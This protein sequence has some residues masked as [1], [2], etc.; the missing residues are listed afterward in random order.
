MIKPNLQEIWNGIKR[1]AKLFYYSPAFIVIILLGLIGFTI[2]TLNPTPI[3]SLYP[4]PAPYP[5]GPFGQLATSSPYPTYTP[6]PTPKP[7]KLIKV[8]GNNKSEIIHYPQG[9][10]QYIERW[11]NFL[12]YGEIKNEE[13]T[14][15][16]L[17]MDTLE[18]RV[19]AHESIKHGFSIG[20]QAINDELFY[21]FKPD[22]GEAT[23]YWT[24]IPSYGISHPL[25]Y[26]PHPSISF[27]R[28]KYWI[29]SGIGEGCGGITYY[30]V[31]DITQKQWKRIFD[32]NFECENYDEVVDIDTT[33]RMLV[34]RYESQPYKVNNVD[35]VKTFASYIFAIPISQPTLKIGVVSKS[36]MPK[37]I[38]YIRYLKEK[39]QLILL[40]N[41][42]YTFD[43]N[44]SKINQIAHIITDED[45]QRSYS[46]TYWASDQVC[47]EEYSSAD[48]ERKY[49]QIN[50]ISKEK[51]INTEFCKHHP[52]ADYFDDSGDIKLYYDNEKYINYLNLPPEFQF[53]TY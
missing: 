8:Q 15:T 5:T 38:E 25:Y 28:N 33:D 32:S 24:S 42:L 45:T 46:L 26:G 6:T 18:K 20:L 31:L 19:I 9:K 12:F 40:G 36:A 48:V 41:E 50:L 27:S 14:I 4:T 16:Q 10:I 2:R 17:N 23:L 22:W 13:G 49:Y 37:G 21:S 44:T 34:A 35:T 39:N 53:V 52:K 30:N 47:I 51:N 29:I 1:E 11:K 7:I 3:T 43:L